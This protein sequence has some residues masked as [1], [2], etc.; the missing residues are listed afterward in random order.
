M[1]LYLYLLLSRGAFFALIIA[2][3]HSS[4]E[5]IIRKSLHIE[6]QQ[7]RQEVLLLDAGQQP[8]IHSY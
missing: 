3:I 2:S 6:V 8:L 1:H 7:R 5:S 4:G